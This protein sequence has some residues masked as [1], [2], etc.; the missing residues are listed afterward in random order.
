MGS[1]RYW[2]FRVDIDWLPMLDGE[3]K[4]G[5]LRQGWGWDQGQ[6]LRVLSV[7]EGAR[8]NLRMFQEVKKN[9]VVL[10]PHLPSYGYVTIVTA[11]EDWEYGYKFRVHPES[12]DHGHIFPA[13]LAVVFNKE[14]ERVPASL[15]QTLRTP[16]RFWCIDDLE[17]A[18]DA[19]LNNPDGLAGAKL[20]RDRWRDI[21]LHSINKSGLEKT[22]S[23]EVN[24]FT[25]SSEWEYVLIDVFQALFPEWT[26]ERTAGH[27]EAVHGTD[28]LLTF[29]QL[30][31]GLYGIAVQVKDHSGLLD[32]SSIDQICKARDGFWKDRSIDVIDTVV[33]VTKAHISDNQT[34]ARYAED[35]GV[36]IL[37]ASDINKL[38]L[39]AAARLVA[40]TYESS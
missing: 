10:V 18:V 13:E 8:R 1:R 27:A 32:N 14:N 16:S 35:K 25:G 31:E 3:L 17:D 33:A 21:A 22:I 2:V 37:W 7:D 4:A 15:R 26:V 20:P 9:D 5:R 6:D 39:R 34:F 38:L 29:P 23:A 30:L 24:E 28:I 40:G 36:K 11:T 19:L 12:H